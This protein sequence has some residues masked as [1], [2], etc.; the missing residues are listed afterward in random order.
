MLLVES[1]P[2]SMTPPLDPFF[3]CRSEDVSNGGQGVRFEIAVDGQAAAAFVVRY[4]G[5][6]RAFLNRCAHVPV[7]LDWMQG[8]F[9]DDEGQYLMCA[10]HGATYRPQDGY[11]VAGPCRGRAL[12]SI[13]C[14][15]QE[16]EVWAGH[17]SGF[18]A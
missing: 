13:P 1:E 2:T 18:D 11:C 12:T 7:E 4:D 9:F 15:E 10:T 16:G 14:F 5:V 3:V 6:V 8:V 17:P